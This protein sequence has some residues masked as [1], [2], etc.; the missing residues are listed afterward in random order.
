MAA[1]STKGQAER[2]TTSAATNTLCTATAKS[3][4]AADIVNHPGAV[5]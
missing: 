4:H 5:H 1:W 2:S 3:L